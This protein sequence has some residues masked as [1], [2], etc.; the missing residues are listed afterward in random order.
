MKKFMYR[1]AANDM[2]CLKI[3]TR[4][5]QI[6]RT[7]LERVASNV[8]KKF[9]FGDAANDMSFTEI[10]PSKSQARRRTGW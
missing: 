3:Y 4:W 9:M 2:S 1:D 5:G 7:A 10:C 6:T 8:M